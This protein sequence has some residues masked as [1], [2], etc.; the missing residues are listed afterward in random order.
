MQFTS[1]SYSLE[2]LF[3]L[4]E[5][6]GFEG[7]DNLFSKLVSPKPKYPAFKAYLYILKDR[8]CIEILDGKTKNS[9]KYIKLTSETKKEFTY[10]FKN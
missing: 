9:S 10:I 7:I 6:D 8:G 2:L 4:E 1:R 3:L 5:M